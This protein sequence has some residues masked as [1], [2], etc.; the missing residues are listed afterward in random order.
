[1]RTTTQ[2]SKGWHGAT[3]MAQ[4]V[5][6]PAAKADD[7]S[8]VLGTHIVEGV[9]PLLKVF[10]PLHVDVCMRMSACAHHPPHTNKQ[11]KWY[12]NIK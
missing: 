1:M 12:K 10:S 8:S 11:I 9:N 7:Q 4:Q 5:K 3:E 6:V 2:P